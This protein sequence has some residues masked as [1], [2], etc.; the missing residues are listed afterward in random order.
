MD[1][2]DRELIEEFLAATTGMTQEQA[3]KMVGVSQRKVSS[4]RNGERGALQSRIRSAME[5]FLRQASYVDTVEGA[6]D[7]ESEMWVASL[8][9]IMRTLRKIGPEPGS[10]T[11]RKK[12]ALRLMRELMATLGES[13]PD[14]YWDI[15]ERV[16]RGEL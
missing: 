16:E 2:T 5:Q 14:W 8:D 1:T 11:A 6:R 12:D 10:R 9:D 15:Q 7:V 4:W 3:A 13:L